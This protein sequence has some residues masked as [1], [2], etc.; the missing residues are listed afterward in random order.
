MGVSPNTTFNANAR[1]AAS[2]YLTLLRGRVGG[3]A[4]VLSVNANDNVL[5]VTTTLLNTGGA[6]NI[7]VSTRSIG[8]TERGT[9]VGGIRSGYRFLINSLTSGVDNGFS[10]VYTGVITSMVVGLFS[11]INSFVRS[12]NILVVSNVVSLEGSSIL[13]STTLRNFGILGRGCG[14][15]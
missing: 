8:A 4:G 5:T 9:R 1:T 7:S 2:L 13:G 14:S 12:G 3:N 11:G 15:G 10:I 6:I